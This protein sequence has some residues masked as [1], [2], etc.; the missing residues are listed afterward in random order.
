MSLELFY[1]PFAP[2]L[3]KAFLSPLVRM[4]LCV[5][6][7]PNVWHAIQ[8]GVYFRSV[9]LGQLVAREPSYGFCSCYTLLVFVCL[10]VSPDQKPYCFLHLVVFLAAFVDIIFF[11]V[12]KFLAFS[13]SSVATRM[14]QLVLNTL[15]ST[16]LLL[17][18]MPSV[19]LQSGMGSSPSLL[20]YYYFLIV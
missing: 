12:P 3:F 10:T 17:G 4:Q 15:C 20:H 14:Q 2:V 16:L 6:V 7:E 19:Y 11:K 13:C 1:T 8:N 9:E 5:P 18:M